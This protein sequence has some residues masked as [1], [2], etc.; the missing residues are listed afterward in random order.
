MVTFLAGLDSGQQDV[1][2]NLTCT[3]AGMA[4]DALQELVRIVIENCMR[5]PSR[6]YVGLCNRWQLRVGRKRQRMTLGAGLPPKKFLRL[7]YSQRDP[8]LRSEN[9]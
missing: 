1:R 4:L 6:R 9:S 2:G 5:K 8:F 3:S 7:G